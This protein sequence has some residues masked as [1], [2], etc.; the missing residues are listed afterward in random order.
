MKPTP[1]GTST[2]RIAAD[3]AIA[4]ALMLAVVWLATLNFLVLQI[5]MI[6]EVLI[7]MLLSLRFVSA[8]ERRAHLI[9]F[10]QTC[11]LSVFLLLFAVLVYRLTHFDSAPQ[12]RVLLDSLAVT[13]GRGSLIASL[14]YLL[15]RLIA[16]TVYAQTTAQPGETWA[17]LVTANTTANLLTLVAMLF[18]V[19]T[20]G[21]PILRALH[22]IDADLPFDAILGSLAAVVRLA[23][24]LLSARI[25]HS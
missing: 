16:L 20:L 22:R 6:A 19:A 5:L 12:W 10:F 23:L 18:V 11:A 9:S 4:C 14:G 21:I 3:E 24:G 13:L 25:S 15:L 1:T 17:R 8:W 7:S 2:I